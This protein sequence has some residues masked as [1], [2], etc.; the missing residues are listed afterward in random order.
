MSLGFCCCLPQPGHTFRLKGLLF[1]CKR[2]CGGHM[3]LLG[4]IK[5]C[6]LFCWG[7]DTMG[8]SSAGSISGNSRMSSSPNCMQL[9]M[10]LWISLA[11][12]HCMLQGPLDCLQ[13][14]CRALA[15]ARV[16]SFLVYQICQETLRSLGGRTASLCRALRLGRRSHHHNILALAVGSWKLVA[17]LL[18]THCIN[19]LGPSLAHS[20]IQRE[21]LWPP[22]SETC[23][24]GC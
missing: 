1:M 20:Q 12:Q 14:L 19:T 18:A 17:C 23:W 11:M 22:L 2:V 7:W 24:K 4:L 3:S 21:K 15:K 5:E 13:Q 9:A 8:M 6:G 16:F 10:H